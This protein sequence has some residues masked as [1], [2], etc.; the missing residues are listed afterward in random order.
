M[1]T[2]PPLR[3]IAA[4]PP[5]NKCLLRDA[6]QQNKGQIPQHKTHFSQRKR[7]STWAVKPSRGGKCLSHRWQCEKTLQ[8]CLYSHD[9]GVPRLVRSIPNF[10]WLSP[11]TLAEVPGPGPMFRVKLHSD[12]GRLNPSSVP[13][14]GHGTSFQTVCVCGGG[15]CWRTPRESW[16]KGTSFASCLVQTQDSALQSSP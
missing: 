1:K 13:Y 9:L 8:D 11:T 7:H 10:G 15:G 6:P 4:A 3:R 16:L 12:S 5:K 14:L 2:P